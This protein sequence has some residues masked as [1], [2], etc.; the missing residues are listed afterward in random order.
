MTYTPL[1]EEFRMK[2]KPRFTEDDLVH[3]S[4]KPVDTNE[5]LI[6]R[7]VVSEN[8]SLKEFLEGKNV[9]FERGCTYYE[10]DGDVESITEDTELIFMANVSDT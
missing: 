8:C 4:L 5:R 7:Y 2:E 6:E 1:V 3:L 10:F 9:R